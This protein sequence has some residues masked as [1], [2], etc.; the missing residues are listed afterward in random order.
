MLGVDLNIV[1][2]RT[3]IWGSHRISDSPGQ[4]VAKIGQM[5]VRGFVRQVETGDPMMFAAEVETSV[6]GGSN[7][8]GRCRRFS[9]EGCQVHAYGAAGSGQVIMR[10][11]KEDRVPGNVSEERV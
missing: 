1:M 11:R 6:E 2:L 7:F 5:L 9:L 4:G 3:F 8:K 10:W